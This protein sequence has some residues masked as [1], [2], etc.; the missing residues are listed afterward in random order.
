MILSINGAGIIGYLH[1]K[2][3]NLT[4]TLHH[5]EKFTEGKP[6]PSMQKAKAS[7]GGN[8]GEYIHDDGVSK[9]VLNRKQKAHTK[10]QKKN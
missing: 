5:N 4:S 10:K 2:K 7:R 6:Q 8:I 1:G 9:K 3:L